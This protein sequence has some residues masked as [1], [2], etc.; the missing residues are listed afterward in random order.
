[1]VASLREP[2]EGMDGRVDEGPGPRAA[3][4]SG[5]SLLRDL[6]SVRLAWREKLA[7]LP[8]RLEA[9]ARLLAD[10]DTESERRL[11]LERIDRLLAALEGR[12]VVEAAPPPAARAPDT[13]RE[14]DAWA[15]E[16]DARGAHDDDQALPARHDTVVMDAATIREAFAADPAMADLVRRL[17]EEDEDRHDT[18]LEM[19][20]IAENEAPAEAAPA[21]EPPPAAPEAAAQPAA[22]PAAEARPDALPTIALPAVEE[23][24]PPAASPPTEEIEAIEEAEL[25][26]EHEPPPEAAR[27][28][29]PPPEQRARTTETPAAPADVA[30]EPPTSEWPREV[31]LLYEDV[32]WLFQLGDIDGALISLERLLVLAPENEEIQ[33]F[34]TLNERKLLEIYQSVLGAWERVPRLVDGAWSTPLARSTGEKVARVLRLIDG[35]RSVQSIVGSSSLSRLE[36]CSVL[37][38]LMRS[39]IIA[40][41]DQPAAGRGA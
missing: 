35:A 31:E 8:A 1:M 30:E 34:V 19:P 32:H 37:S 29:S 2:E 11:R 18:V 17:Q 33:A 40:F 23:P 21:A 13:E 5:G 28:P 12:A 20:A 15:A 24:A 4:P 3:G 14:L 38:Q 25:L 22:A 9:R 16:R 26:V 10:P 36:A 6:A 27:P 39:R 7:D 41:D